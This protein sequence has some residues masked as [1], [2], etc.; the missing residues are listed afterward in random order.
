MSATFASIRF[1]ASRAALALAV[2]AFALPT[3]ARAGDDSDR[4]GI[5]ESALEGV[6]GTSGDFTVRNIARASVSGS[7]LRVRLGNQYGTQSITDLPPS[8]CSRAR[9]S[10]RSF[11]DLCERSRR[12]R[13]VA[14]VVGGAGHRRNQGDH[15]LQMNAVE[16]ATSACCNRLTRRRTECTGRLGAWPQRWQ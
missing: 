13:R 6:H 16:A 15:L 9:R 5:W 11:P 14:S 3:A 10:R 7:R 12:R 4:F 2:A 1:W 8:A